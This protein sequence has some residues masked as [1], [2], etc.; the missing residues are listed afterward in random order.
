MAKA[1]ATT[2][3]R[4]AAPTFLVSVPRG[5]RIARAVVAMAVTIRAIQAVTPT[6]PIV[7]YVRAYPLSTPPKTFDTP[8]NP[9][10][11]NGRWTTRENRKREAF[12]TNRG[13]VG[14]RPGGERRCHE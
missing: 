5:E 4:Q 2:P 9:R 3:M 8:L 6:T 1:T 10:P 13:R 11:V 7:A 12:E 14:R